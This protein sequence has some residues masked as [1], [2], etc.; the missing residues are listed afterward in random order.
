MSLVEHPLDGV[1][2]EKV[3][4]RAACSPAGI[5]Y[6]EHCLR[7]MLQRGIDALDLVRLLRSAEMTC[8][9]YRRGGEW[10]YRVRE[11]A[12]NAPPME[13]KSGGGRGDRKRGS[14]RGAHRLPPKGPLI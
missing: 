9:P 12:G 10:R 1:E 14:H 4:R 6:R 13:T 2:A 3:I 5:G 8:Q 11:R 7:R